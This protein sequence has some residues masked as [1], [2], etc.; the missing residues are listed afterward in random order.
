MIQDLKL[1]VFNWTV[2]YRVRFD[3]MVT[4]DGDMDEVKGDLPTE[5][6]VEGA[7]A[8]DKKEDYPSSSSSS[9]SSSS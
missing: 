1:R 2:E 3:K 6:L 7:A 4:A 5:D 9:A 8:M